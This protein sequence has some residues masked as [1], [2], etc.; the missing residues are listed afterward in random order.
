MRALAFLAMFSVLAACGDVQ[1][2][3]DLEQAK[4]GAINLG[5][6][7]AEAAS[8][9]V[10]TRMACTL[11]GQSEAFCGCLQDRIGP[12]IRP[13]HIEAVTNVIRGTLNGEGVQATIE[14]AQGIDQPTREALLQCATNAAVQGAAN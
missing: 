7:A 12:R 8:N 10:D 9:V 11:A 13:E 3:S 2:P 5:Q 4:E 1:V 6:Q 14:G